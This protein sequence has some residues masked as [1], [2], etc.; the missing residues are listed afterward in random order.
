MQP[1]KLKLMRISPSNHTVEKSPRLNSLCGSVKAKTK[2]VRS[3]ENNRR[4]S[5]G[6]FLDGND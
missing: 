5:D 1:P 3:L 2:R 4:K 6:Y